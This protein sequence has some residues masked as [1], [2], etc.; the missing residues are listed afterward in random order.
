MNNNLLILAGACA[1]IPA[2][3]RM[4]FSW[5]AYGLRLQSRYAHKAHSDSYPLAQP[6]DE[7]YDPARDSEL[8]LPQLLYGGHVPAV[9]DGDIEELA[10]L[11]VIPALTDSHPGAVLQDHPVIASPIEPGKELVI[12]MEIAYMILLPMAEDKTESKQPLFSWRPQHGSYEHVEAVFVRD[13]QGDCFIDLIRAFPDFSD[14]TDRFAF[15]QFTLNDPRMIFRMTVRSDEVSFNVNG[16]D[17]GPVPYSSTED[18]P[19]QLTILGPLVN[20]QGAN[21]A[22]IYHVRVDR[23][24]LNV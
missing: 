3:E 12:S 13:D 24:D 23:R 22:E 9:V 7:V 8:Q 19:G 11:D 14:T 21:I 15:D 4:D 20:E 6:A 5:S 1:P 10:R 16:L 2:P 17:F 18:G